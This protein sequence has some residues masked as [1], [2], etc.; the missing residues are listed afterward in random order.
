VTTTEPAERVAK[1]KRGSETLLDMVRSLG[2]ILVVVAV[3]LLFVPGL[4]HP[5]KSD[6]FPAFDYSDDVAGFHQVTGL[7]ALA[8]VSLPSGWKANAGA[9]TGPARAEHLHIGWATPGSKYA[10]LEESVVPLNRFAVSVLGKGT[11]IAS[12]T[13][14]I[15]G[16]AWQTRTSARGEYSLTRRVGGISVVV[17][18]S[19]TDARLRLLAASLR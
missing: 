19:A 18:G 1:P 13:V 5:S 9:L 2:L 8:P 14:S 17:T 7:T 10:G 4:V 15:G 16:V 12:G 3:T 6:R 11:S